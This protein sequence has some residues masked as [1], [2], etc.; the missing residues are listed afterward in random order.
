MPDASQPI[1]PYLL[2]ADV[3]D[4][5]DWLTE[6]FGFEERLRFT[7]DD[8]RVNHA[9]MT[10]GD[11]VIMLGS[12]G[13]DF[14][15]PDSLGGVTVLI[16]VEVPDVDAHYQRAVA[17]GATIVKPP[18]DEP[19]GDR[20]YDANDPAGHLWSFATRIR[21]VAPAEWGATER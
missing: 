14:Q 6:A 12:P 19:Y 16:H 8:E 9:E 4:A 21:D 5:I 11:G 13:P 15:G 3:A 20:R 7:G 10:L 18:G 1:T 17:A 2:Y